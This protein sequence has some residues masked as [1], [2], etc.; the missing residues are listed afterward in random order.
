MDIKRKSLCFIFFIFSFFSINLNSTDLSPSQTVYVTSITYSWSSVG[1]NNYVAVLSTSPSFSSPISSATLS[2]N[3]TTYQSLKGNTTYYFKVKISTESDSYYSEISTLTYPS[4][5]SSLK[6]IYNEQWESFAQLTIDFLNENDKDTKYQVRYST[7]DDFSLYY[8]IYYTG[9][10]PLPINSLLTNTTYYIKIKAIDRINRETEFSNV[11]ST[12]TL[13]KLPSAFSVSVFETSAT[14]NWAPVNGTGENSSD[15]Y[16]LIISEKDNLDTVLYSYITPDNSENNY[17]FTSLNKNSTYYYM[18]SVL[19]SIK[20]KNSIKGTI[21]TLTSKPSN[22]SLL[23]YSSYSATLGWDAFPSSPLTETALGY[24]LEASTSANFNQIKTSAT[25]VLSISTLTIKS[26]EANTTYHFRVG[27]INHYGD[28]NYSAVIETVT[29]SVPIDYNSVGYIL[30]PRSITANFPSMPSD[31]EFL[32]S[33]GYRLDLSTTNFIGGTVYSSHTLSFEASSLTIENLRPNTTYYSRLYTFNRVLNEN[34]YGTKK[35]V[36]PIPNISPDVNVT[37]YSSN[38]VIVNYS[39]TDADGYIIELSTDNYFRVI[40]FSSKT[41]SNDISTLAIHTLNFDTLYYIRQGSLFEG[42]TIYKNA[43]P[44]NIRTLTPPPSS[45]AL[46]KVYISSVSANWTAVPCKGYSLEAST[47]SDFSVIKTSITLFDTVSSLSV[48]NL[49]PNTTYH[50][51]VGSINSDNQRNYTYITSTP[52]L[53]NFPSELP[54]TNHTTYSMQINWSKNS[55]PDDTLYLA[56]IS[57]TNFTSGTTYSSYTY[58][59]YALFDN[60]QSNTTYYKKITAFN[61]R[62]IP[63][64]PISFNPVATLAFK[65]IN[66]TYV[67]S[68][69]TIVLN[70]EDPNN[71][72]GTPYLAEI[73]SKAFSDSIISSSTLAKSAT[74]Y[75]LN[76]NTPY[77]IR[78]SAINFSNIPSIYETALSTTYVEIPKITT[79]TFINVLLD[80]FTAQWDNNTNSTHT[81]YVVEASTTSDFSYIFKSTQTK[82]TLFVFPD[83]TYNTDYFI[84]VKSRGIITGNESEYLDLGSISTLYRQEQLIN[85]QQNQIVSIPYSY[86][87]IQVELPPYSL[88]SVTKVFIEPDLSPPP[89]V[90]KAGV[91]NPTGFAAKIW[92]FP[93]VLYN[94]KILVKIPYKDLPSS[95]DKNKLVM[96][97]YDETAKLWVPIKS[98]IEGNY[99]VGETYHFSIFQIMELLASQSLK[100]P[101]IY[102]NPYKPNTSL[103]KINFSNMPSNTEISIYSITGELIKKLKTNDGGF[104]QWDAKN[105]S[106]RD[107]SSGVYLV[108]FKSQNGEKV[109]KKLAIEK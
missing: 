25:Y 42:T 91:L 40:N 106:Q 83:L 20:Y 60:L 13:S 21:H 54:L 103:G 90:S 33:Y 9:V 29:L 68:T 89:P 66:L 27:A 64:G 59:N 61:R 55:N 100:D 44:F 107:V 1:S 12:Q 63:T 109:I 102:P 80:G 38:T 56:Q 50:L 62:N 49:T 84:R 85:N 45:A 53:A 96:A 48:T 67:F 99:V 8:D 36:T 70:W 28:K 78:I 14:F 47:S 104:V 30:N 76:A 98:Y 5:P 75:N 22:F 79:P 57:S 86:G 52:T 11:L 31:V 43:S 4:K 105:E 46:D 88:G 16:E 97:R 35:L 19:N 26:L 74:F 10:P 73:S 81:L 82:M 24:V 69:H 58:N 37:Y 51:R 41:F 101:K 3:T 15:G 95:I 93:V 6:A 7:Y 39:T 18:F 32:K 94:G 23:N 34:Y 87:S 77:F 17:S 65:P 108:I 92:I 71:A 72:P 2:S